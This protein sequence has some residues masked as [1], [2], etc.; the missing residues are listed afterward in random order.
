MSCLKNQSFSVAV[1]TK[2]HTVVSF[3]Y[4]GQAHFIED[5]EIIKHKKHTVYR[6]LQELL[7][8]RLQIPSRIPFH[9]LHET[10]LRHKKPEKH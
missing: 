7:I 4:A 5:K 1:H 6:V 3:K 8:T 2:T 10:W 9:A